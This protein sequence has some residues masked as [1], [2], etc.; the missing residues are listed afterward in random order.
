MLLH[1]EKEVIEHLE[2]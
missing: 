1:K 2:Y